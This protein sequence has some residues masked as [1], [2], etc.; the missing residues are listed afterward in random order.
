M[1]KKENKLMDMST[2]F[3]VDILQLVTYLQENKVGIIPNQIGRSG[4][5][6]GANVREAQYAQGKKDFVSKLKIALKEANETTYWLELLLKTNAINKEYFED[7]NEKC[8]AI[9]L[10]LI[11]S[12]NTAQNSFKNNEP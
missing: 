4:T 10:V 9:K 2:N 6:I 5:S 1:D 3:A 8:T 12:C 11:K 7:L